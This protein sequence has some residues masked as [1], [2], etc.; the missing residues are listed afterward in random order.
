VRP[1]G[2]PHTAATW[3]DWEDGRALLNMEDT[4]L[5]LRYLRAEPRISL[6]VLA[7]GDW[8][9]QVTLLGRVGAIEEDVDLRDIDRLALRY[10]GKPYRNR[11]RRRFS[12]WLEP[13]RW[14]AWPPRT[15]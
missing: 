1:D 7:E 9:R 4:R 8:Y 10:T 15:R 5:R 6:T 12:A 14:Y 3:Y 11:S 2:S 13:E